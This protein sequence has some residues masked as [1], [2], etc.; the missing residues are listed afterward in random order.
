MC[1]R[2]CVC[3]FV[4]RLFIYSFQSFGVL[5]KK[6]LGAVPRF[7]LGKFSGFHFGVMEGGFNRV[8]GCYLL[9]FQFLFFLVFL[10]TTTKN[11]NKKM[12]GIVEILLHAVILFEIPN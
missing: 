7:F 12:V 10:C 1:A 2:L 11:N 9:L 4:T 8:F 3:V 6:E 5:N